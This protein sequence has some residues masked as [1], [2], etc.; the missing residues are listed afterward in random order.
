MLRLH[1]KAGL[2][3]IALLALCLAAA[4]QRIRTLEHAAKPKTEEW[5]AEARSQ[6]RLRGPSRT[7][8]T[9][10]KK[11]DGTQVTKTVTDRGPELLSTQQAVASERKEEPASLRVPWRFAGLEL[12][13]DRHTAAR[14]GVSFG[15]VEL[16]VRHEL[17]YGGRLTFN[18]WVGVGFRW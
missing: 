16:S 9:K 6:E 18:P 2:V 7:T 5:R 11:P 8:T 12:A 1:E 4:L 17:P 3:V 10:V 13:R 15:S 14:L